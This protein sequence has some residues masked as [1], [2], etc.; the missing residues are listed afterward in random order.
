M[1]GVRTLDGGG[2]TLDVVRGPAALWAYRAG[3]TVRFDAR[4]LGTW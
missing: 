3:L 2:Q 1:A 4:D